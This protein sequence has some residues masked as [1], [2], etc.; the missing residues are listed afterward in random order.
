MPDDLTKKFNVELLLL[1][2]TTIISRVLYEA[3]T[4]CVSSPN[5]VAQ[6][7][8]LDEIIA[9]NADTALLI[10]HVKRI[11]LPD[12]MEPLPIN[13][14]SELAHVDADTITLDLMSGEL[15]FNITFDNTTGL[16][17][18]NRTSYT[19]LPF[20]GLVFTTKEITD[21]ILHVRDVF[22]I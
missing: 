12:L 19:D 9:G 3:S 10:E 21:F 2:G 20:T 14:A 17:D 4:S 1:I 8:T 16:F 13:T 22:G 11:G 7:L 15:E 18:F 5:V 6:S